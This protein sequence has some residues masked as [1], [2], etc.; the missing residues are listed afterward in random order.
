MPWW[1]GVLGASALIAAN[2]LMLRRIGFRPALVL[3]LVPLLVGAEMGY[4][5]AYSYAPKFLHAW[6]L[7]TAS[8]ATLGLVS[9]YMIDRTIAVWD[10]VGVICIAVGAYLLGR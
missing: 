5:Y 3:W 6:F 9:S 2:N 7:G 8:M 1:L 10:A 4:S